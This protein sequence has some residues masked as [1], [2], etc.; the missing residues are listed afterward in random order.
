[1]TGEQLLKISKFVLVSLACF[2]VFG[3]TSLVISNNDIEEWEARNSLTLDCVQEKNLPYE[4][5]DRLVVNGRYP[6]KK[7]SDNE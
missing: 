3:Y 6:E 7:V 5:C 1:M 4:T 2:M